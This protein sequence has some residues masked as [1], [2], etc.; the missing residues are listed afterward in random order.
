MHALCNSL[1]VKD[2]HYKALAHYYAAIAHEHAADVLGELTSTILFVTI[3]STISIPS[4][5]LVVVRLV[6]MLGLNYI[7]CILRVPRR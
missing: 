3:I 4:L 2:A 7:S 6:R 1:Q 5:Q